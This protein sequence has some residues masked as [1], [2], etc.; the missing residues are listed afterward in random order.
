MRFEKA[1]NLIKLALLMQGSSLGVSLQDICQEFTVSRRTAERMRDAVLHLFPQGGETE[2]VERV[3]HWKISGRAANS[4]LSVS[5]DE[6]GALSTANKFLRDAGADEAADHIRDLEIKLKA[7]TSQH[8]ARFEPDLEALAEA[9]GLAMRPGPRPKV[10]SKIFGALRNSLLGCTKVRLHYRSRETGQLSRQVV[11]P[12]GFLYGNRHYLV[13]YSMNPEARDFRLFVLDNIEKLDELD[14]SFVRQSD[15]SLEEYAQNSFGV[16]QGDP[17]DVAW[18]FTPEVANDARTF[19]F[20]P[21]QTL[22]DQPDGSLIVRFRASGLTEMAWHLF[23]WGDDV[24][25][26]EPKKL[27]EELDWWKD[28]DEDDEE[29]E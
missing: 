20:H 14:E 27:Q 6:L 17:V 24:E 25:I 23:T 7:A 9:E 18:Q 22:E 26:L 28:Y 11:C 10:D 16:Y 15:F 13:A 29:E 4:L 3:K 8:S 5:R 2:S 19:L 12:Y 21:S 1:E